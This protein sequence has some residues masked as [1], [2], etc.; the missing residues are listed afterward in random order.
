MICARNSTVANKKLT[1][2]ERRRRKNPQNRHTFINVQEEQHQKSN[3][4]KRGQ[5]RNNK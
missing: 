5:K 4:R 2:T 1:M 3:E